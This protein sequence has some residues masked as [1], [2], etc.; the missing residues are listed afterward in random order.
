MTIHKSEDLLR[1][2]AKVL[3]LHGMLAHWD[4]ISETGWIESLIPDPTDRQINFD[5]SL[6]LKDIFE[7]ADADLRHRLEH[8]YER[9]LRRWVQT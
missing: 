7:T 4:E 6:A 8:V 1:A 9:L 2:R 5:L 3:K